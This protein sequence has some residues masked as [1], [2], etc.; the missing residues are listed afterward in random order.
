M[1]V[2]MAQKRGRND[3]AIEKLQ[4]KEKVIEK[5]QKNGFRAQG[6]C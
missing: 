6:M 1:L 2:E 5:A 4:K 3:N